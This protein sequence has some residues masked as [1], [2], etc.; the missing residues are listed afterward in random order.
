M[1]GVDG[2][3]PPAAAVCVSASHALRFNHGHYSPGML[4]GE[5]KT[6]WR[7]PAPS[8][9]SSDAGPDLTFRQVSPFALPDTRRTKDSRRN[10]R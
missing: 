9:S 6:R 8:H 10:G 7:E 2:R 5:V 1:G 4:A 3:A